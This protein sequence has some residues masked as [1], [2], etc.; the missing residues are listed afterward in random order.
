MSKKKV[1]N[2][3]L[4][5]SLIILSYTQ[6]TFAFAIFDNINPP[7]NESS[8]QENI[9]EDKVNQIN[10]NQML[11]ENKPTEK[12]ENIPNDEYEENNYTNNQNYELYEPKEI[13]AYI[14]D[15][16]L[17]SQDSSKNIYS[18]SNIN[19]K[20]FWE[21]E[22][23]IND[24]DYIK[25][26]LP[27]T[28]NSPVYL[29]NLP[30]EWVIYDTTGKI[31]IGKAIIQDNY[32]MVIFNK[33]I[34][35]IGNINNVISFSCTLMTSDNITEENSFLTIKTGDSEFD[36][37]IQIEEK[38]KN[39]SI[40]SQSSSSTESKESNNGTSSLQ[41]VI[42]GAEQLSNYEYSIYTDPNLTNY[43]GSGYSDKNGT[44][45]IEDLPNGNYYAKMTKA[46]EGYVI[47]P[48]TIYVELDSDKVFSVDVTNYAISSEEE[49]I[50]NTNQNTLNKEKNDEIQTNIETSIQATEYD[51][52][53]I[54]SSIEEKEINTTNIQENNTIKA[55]PQTGD[56]HI[57]IILAS[58]LICF[59][60]LL[61]ILFI[62]KKV[63]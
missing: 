34:E 2:T 57:N 58:I 37:K 63:L 49:T 31:D 5:S 47:V 30:T 15:V 45:L 40:P 20:I 56:I 23:V 62:L 16:S 43:V 55:N 50:T 14:T 51:D 44:I 22:D 1:I 4:I 25:F 60:I 19:L 17:T 27:T 61:F 11:E 52:M 7:I 10:E 41:I 36:Y 9:S 35:D 42:T 33:N 53:S 46:A 8:T 29:T 26:E 38:N 21:S 13:D 48:E 39:N 18:G 3:F 24:E 28:Q 54:N 32:L 12:K 59:I 6:V